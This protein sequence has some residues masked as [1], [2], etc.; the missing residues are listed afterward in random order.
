M[1]SG[2]SDPEFQ[3]RN[4]GSNNCPSHLTGL[5][6]DQVS[7]TISGIQ[8]TPFPHADPLGRVTTY[9]TRVQRL[10]GAVFLFVI[11]MLRIRNVPNWK[12]L[13]ICCIRDCGYF[14]GLQIVLG[15]EIIH[16]DTRGMDLKFLR[17]QG[18]GIH[19]FGSNNLAFL[20]MFSG[21][22]NVKVHTVNLS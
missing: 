4:A 14:M 9:K 12:Q 18:C 13:L 8:P 11:S 20:L 2:K 7:Y 10:R 1:T 16:L 19:S 21:Q 3:F 22:T 5:Q 15:G 6:Y 17:P